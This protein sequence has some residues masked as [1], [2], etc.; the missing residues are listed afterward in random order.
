[1]L[2]TEGRRLG[3]RVT[4]DDVIQGILALKA[5]IG[6]RPLVVIGHVPGS[7]RQNLYDLLTRPRLP[8][9]PA[10]EPDRYLLMKPMPDILA[11]NIELRLASK[12][13]GQFL[14]LDPHDVLCHEGE[15]R[16]TTRKNQ[17][18]YSDDVG[19]LSKYGSV[20]VISGFVDQLRASMASGQTNPTMASHGVRQ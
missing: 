7:G 15:C 9:S 14:F 4:V 2:D 8:F 13:S 5:R 19:H 12:Q 16:N 17:L 3:K 11:L 6:A 18:V 10:V 1:M 20:E